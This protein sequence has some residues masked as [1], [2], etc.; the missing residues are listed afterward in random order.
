MYY[1]GAEEAA[2]CSTS[3]RANTATRVVVPFG[4][5]A[6]VHARKLMAMCHIFTVAYGTDAGGGRLLV[7]LFR[8][9]STGVERIELF[10][11]NRLVSTETCMA[12]KIIPTKN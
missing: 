9:H 1:S 5:H 3:S 12:L 2:V 6:L 10:V 11:D 8:N 4:Y 7:E